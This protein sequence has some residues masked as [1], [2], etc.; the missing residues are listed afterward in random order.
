MPIVLIIF[1]VGVFGVLYGLTRSFL[2]EWRKGIWFAGPGTILTVLSLFLIAGLNN[3]SFYPSN[4]DL[5]SSLTITNSSSSHYTLT[6]MSYVSLFVPFVI[7]YIVYAWRAINNKPI[8]KEEI[9]NKSHDIH[10]Y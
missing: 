3:T 7:A 8:D 1:L 10:I 2:S 5:Q 4:A 9:E 6:A